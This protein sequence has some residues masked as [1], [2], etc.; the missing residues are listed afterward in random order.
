MP[1]MLQWLGFSAILALASGC[2]PQAS[3]K[4]QITLQRFFG[5]CEA[6]YGGSTDVAAAQDECGIITTLVN[7]FNAANPDVRVRVNVVYWPGYDQ[8]SAAL[9]AGNPPDIVSMHQ[10][11]IS[12]YAKRGLI[13]PLTAGLADVGITADSFTSA[14]RQ[15]V[16]RDGQIY[17][18]PFDNWAPLWH[19]NLNLFRQA[20]LARGDTPVL[21]RSSEELITQARQFKRITGKPYF[22]QSMVNEPS[23][24]AR[25]LFTFLMQQNS[26]FFSDP[27]HINLTTPEARRV[28]LLFKQI[29]DEGLSTKDQDYSAAT[30]AFMNG[31]G[32]VYLVGT[33][34]IGAYDQ[35]SK[36]ANSPLHKGYTV[37]PY[38][39]L[40][41]ARE[42]TY[43]DGHA[44]AVTRGARSPAQ[45]AAV[46]R[47][48]RFLKDEDFE[49]S[50]SGH[51]PAYQEVID[52]AAWQQLPYRKQLSTL[53]DNAQAL[54][55]G[56]QRQYLIQQ[57]VSQEMQSGI[58][59]QKTVDAALQDAQRRINDLLFNVI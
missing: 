52:S 45:V 11:V 40:F 26:D 30:S 1:R 50:R 34:M 53:V 54:P 21:P 33:W 7:K 6:Q 48:L 56:V 32:G 4:V 15:G 27:K 46:F 42:A 22:I 12:D 36:S 44:W 55:T 59:G 29:Y 49:W 13:L 28:L 24:Y 25:N 2:Q 17:A 57:I 41:G 16:V 51:L 10:A 43:A 23:T 18:L 58:T 5:A 3:G 38:P 8:L 19:I 39:Q 9:A 14:A 31:Q 35:A 47:F 37:V 20:G